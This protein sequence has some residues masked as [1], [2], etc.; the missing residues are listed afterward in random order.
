MIDMTSYLLI[1]YFSFN[2]CKVNLQYEST[3]AFYQYFLI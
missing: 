2:D 1:G 3:D